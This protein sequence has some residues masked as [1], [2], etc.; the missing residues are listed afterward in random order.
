MGLEVER[1]V[2]LVQR[3]VLGRWFAA[4]GWQGMRDVNKL[5][6]SAGDAV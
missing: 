4:D 6:P 3:W 1:D 5:R 2:M